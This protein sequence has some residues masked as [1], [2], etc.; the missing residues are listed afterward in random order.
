MLGVTYL[1]L[2]LTAE[3]L[4]KCSWPG[5]LYEDTVPAG[6]NKIRTTEN[7]GNQY[8]NTQPGLC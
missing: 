5:K 2:I 7:P 8:T 4:N 6:Y 3:I 1:N